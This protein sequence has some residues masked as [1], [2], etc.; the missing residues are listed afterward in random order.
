MQLGDIYVAGSGS[1]G[2]DFDNTTVFWVAVDKYQKA[3]SVD[4]AFSK[5][6]NGKIGTYSKYFPSKEDVFFRGMNPGDKHT[7][8]C[9]INETTTVRVK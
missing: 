5:E 9:W 4:P 2:D 7:V 6:A 1:C 8:G 3:K